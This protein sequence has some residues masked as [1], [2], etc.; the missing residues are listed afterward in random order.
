MNHQGRIV[1]VPQICGGEPVFGGTRVTFRTV[2]ASLAAGDSI[3]EI[4]AAFPALKTK[5]K[6]QSRPRKD[7]AFASR[8]AKAPSVTRGFIDT[9]RRLPDTYYDKSITPVVKHLKYCRVT[10]EGKGVEP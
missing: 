9:K 8:K 6:A 10:E 3:E 7:A 5:E 1:R 2:L 4:V